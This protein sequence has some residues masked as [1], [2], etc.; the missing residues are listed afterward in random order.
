PTLFLSHGSPMMAV[1]K[2]VT[3]DFFK[4]LGARLVTTY[5]PKA[6]LI[7]SAHWEVPGNRV[8]VTTKSD[9][10]GFPKELYEVKY[11]AIGNP[12]LA[13]RVG[14]ALRDAGI[15]CV[16]QPTRGLDHGAWVPLVHM[17]PKADIPVVQL[18]LSSSL[19]F[20]FHAKIGQALRPLR[21]EGVLI[22]AS[23]GAVHNLRELFGPKQPWA[24]GFDKA[25]AEAITKPESDAARLIAM[26]GLVQAPTFKGAHP[27]AEHFI[28][29]AVAAGA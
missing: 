10:G 15:E 2:D 5:H 6:I 11:D 26:A 17:F 13:E 29:V 27:R 12:A 19:D 18:S 22:I 16:S 21:D 23:G 20:D 8:A 3:T 7:I 28:P 14:G 9:F 1:E 25:L 4:Q 24:S